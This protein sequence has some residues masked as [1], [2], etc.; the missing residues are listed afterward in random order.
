MRSTTILTT[1]RVCPL[2]SA[3]V[4]NPYLQGKTD[5]LGRARTRCRCLTSKGSAVRVCLLPPHLDLAQKHF[6]H[7]GRCASHP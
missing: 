7:I 6:R 4:Q 5:V 2:E 3:E 1:I